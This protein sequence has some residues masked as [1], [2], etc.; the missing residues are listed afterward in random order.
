MSRVFTYCKGQRTIEDCEKVV[1]VERAWEIKVS[2]I[3][4]TCVWTGQKCEN[5]FVGKS[6]TLQLVQGLTDELAK[7]RE[8]Q[9]N[10]QEILVQCVERRLSIRSGVPVRVSTKTST[11]TTMSTSS[12]TSSAASTLTTT[13]DE[14]A[15]TTHVSDA[16]GAGSGA[17]SSSSGSDNP[18]CCPD[19]AVEHYQC[20]QGEYY[21]QD[22]QTCILC[23]KDCD[24]DTLGGTIANGTGR[25]PILICWVA[26]LL[27]CSL[28]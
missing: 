5:A 1:S 20:Q 15:S 23:T 13:A 16:D 28:T 27:I 24:Q 22:E 6:T 19:S 8:E 17:S 12:L 10:Q 9:L 26:L 3:Y 14:I 21:L 4:P 18:G 25:P 11:G 7:V 2:G